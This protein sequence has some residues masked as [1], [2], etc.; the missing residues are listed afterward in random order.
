MWILSVLD[1]YDA[2]GNA[3]TLTVYGP[4]IEKRLGFAR[5]SVMPL[6]INGTASLHWSRDDS[7]MGFGFE[8]P[9]RME[10]QRAYQA[11]VYGASTRYG[12]ALK[13]SK[14]NVTQGL[15][16]LREAEKFKQQITFGA[17]NW[18]WLEPWGMHATADAVNAGL[19]DGA[20]VHILS[21]M[22]A[23][24]FNSTLQ[25]PSLSNFESYFILKALARVGATEQ[26]MWLVRR[27]WG[28]LLQY[29][30]STFWERFDPQWADVGA[31]GRHLPPAN[32]MND[33]TSMCHPWASGVAPFLTKTALGI[34]QTSPGYRTF[35]VSPKYFGIGGLTHIQG[36]VPTP[37]G[38]IT[39]TWNVSQT[40][41]V[42]EV[43]VPRGTVGEVVLPP[44]QGLSH[45][46]HK[47]FAS[48]ATIDWQ[49]GQSLP[50]EWEMRDSLGLTSLPAG[51]H[52]IEF[53]FAARETL[54]SFGFKSTAPPKFEYKAKYVGKDISTGGNWQ[55]HYG[56]A[57]YMLFNLTSGGDVVRLP[58]FV[59]GIWAPSIEPS[60]GG[61]PYPTP[62]RISCKSWPITEDVD[63]GNSRPQQCVRT[64]S[65]SSS[66]KRIPRPPAALSEPL[67]AVQISGKAWN[68]F[69]VDIGLNTQERLYNVTLYIADY[70]RLG[71]RQV[72]KMMDLDTLETIAPAVIAQDVA[73]NGVY[74]TYQYN[75]GVRFR[76]NPLHTAGSDYTTGSLRGSNAPAS[77]TAVFID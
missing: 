13:D 27:H 2:N 68:S 42:C 6:C 9:D 3:S 66:D 64:F 71:G 69:H 74:F 40:H 57:G 59:S 55:G 51:D 43:S 77:L 63:L 62:G 70:G 12:N 32:A 31:L 56:S 54:E 44:C 21:N 22:I 29:D 15:Y 53:R 58:D 8:N 28:T 38:A 73:Q 45:V 61:P 72:I 52:R 67:Q 4:D 26:A 39:T 25:L 60:Q 19:L 49:F 48:G 24:R 14:L 46:T 41:G 65:A 35:R 11:L 17:T 20:P 33:R 47:S 10:A 23:R 18:S 7:R 75:R 34:M 30:V 36:A 50:A 5:D 76:F 37:L 1:F 16:W